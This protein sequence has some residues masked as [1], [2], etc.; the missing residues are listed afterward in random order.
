M[1]PYPKTILSIEDQI[2]TLENIG[3]TLPENEIVMEK[4]QSIG[5]YRLRGYWGQIYNNKE[6]K[7]I[8]PAEFMEIVRLYQFDQALKAVLIEAIAK[9]E[10]SLRVRISEALLVYKDALVLQDSTAFR[11][12]KHFWEN[13]AKISVEIGRASDYFIKHN[14]EQHDGAIPIWAAVEVMSFGNLSKI[15]KNMKPVKDEP[16]GALSVLLHHYIKQTGNGGSFTPKED[17]FFSWIHSVSDLRNI[18][19]HNGRLYARAMSTR[20]QLL[21]K[22][23]QELPKYCGVY[24][25]ILA[26]KYL[27]PTKN[28]W[29]EFLAK[30]NA[31]FLQYDGV[32]EYGEM[33]FPEDWK[34]HL[35][36]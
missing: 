8:R 36:T 35:A 1:R 16:D 30:L 14:Y 5:Y 15:V 3:M 11:S 4:L 13:L 20:P 18:C 21:K 2:K 19:A 23:K 33:G 7:L 31:L 24:Y 34:E 28:D 6:K 32:F 10:V 29:N 27:A 25:P 9:I 26:M 22:D 12:K 17:M